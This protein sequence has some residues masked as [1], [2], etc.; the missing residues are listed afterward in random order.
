MTTRDDGAVV[1]MLGPSGAGKG[2]Q[3]KRLAQAMALPHTSSGDLLRQF[4]RKDNYIAEA[5]RK[6]ILIS[7][8][9]ICSVIFSRI[10]HP[11]CCSGFILD[12]FP[13]QAEALDECFSDLKSRDQKRNVQLLAILLIVDQATAAQRLADRRICP[14]CTFV[15]D[16]RKPAA[17]G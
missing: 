4:K 7:H 13:E 12:G 11:D 10:A 5:M 6:G 15:Y 1:I 17:E 2:T 16:V 8:D 9:L 14:T 3:S